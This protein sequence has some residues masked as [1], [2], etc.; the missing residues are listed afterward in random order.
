M[1][2]CSICGKSYSVGISQRHRRGVA[3]KRWAKRAQETKRY[4]MPNVQTKTLVIGGKEKKMKVCA[5]CIKRIRKFGSIKDYPVV[6][7]A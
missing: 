1:A 5:K 3:G 4:F 2:T 7:V 6:A